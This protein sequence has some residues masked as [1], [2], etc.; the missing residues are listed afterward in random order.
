MRLPPRT[1]ALWPTNWLPAVGGYIFKRKLLDVETTKPVIWPN[2][3]FNQHRKG[4]A[5]EKHVQKLCHDF[6]TSTAFPGE[7]DSSADWFQEFGDQDLSSHIFHIHLSASFAFRKFSQAPVV[8]FLGTCSPAWSSGWSAWG[9]KPTR[10]KHSLKRPQISQPRRLF[11]F[12]L[13]INP[14]W[15]MKITPWILVYILST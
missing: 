10:H 11:T 5:I 12:S 9:E 1:V 13:D 3:G 4:M 6:Y 7:V 14:L 15:K 8:Q 2:W